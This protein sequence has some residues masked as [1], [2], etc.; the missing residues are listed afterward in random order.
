MGFFGSIVC[1]RGII[2]FLVYVASLKWLVQS[3]EH[4]LEHALEAYIHHT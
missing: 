4:E 2:I 1:C 3:I